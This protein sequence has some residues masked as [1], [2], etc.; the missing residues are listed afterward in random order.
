M[1]TLLELRYVRHCAD[2]AIPD[3]LASTQFLCLQSNSCTLGGHSNYVHAVAFSP[4]GK[5]V[6]SASKDWTVRLWDSATGT[7]RCTLEGHSSYATAVA[8]SPDSKLVASASMDQTVRLWDA[9][10]A[11][12][13]CVRQLGVFVEQETARAGRPLKLPY[14]IES[15]KIDDVSIQLGIAQDDLWS[16]A[17]MYTLACCKFLLAHASNVNR[18]VGG[19]MALQVR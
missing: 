2:S 4:D 10:V 16:K 7:A 5:L 11:F 1:K 8:F 3:S 12:L 17:C 6:A 14:K 15:E 18:R 13:E 19:L 9:M